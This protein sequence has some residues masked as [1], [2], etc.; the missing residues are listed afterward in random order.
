MMDILPEVSFAPSINRE[1]RKCQ[2]GLICSD[3]STYTQNDYHVINC[4]IIQ[5]L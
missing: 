3:T 5:Q 4:T 2:I 1:K